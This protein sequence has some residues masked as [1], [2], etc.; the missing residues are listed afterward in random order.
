LIQGLVVG[1]GS[2]DRIADL[3]LPMA[4]VYG[5]ALAGLGLAGINLAGA[6]L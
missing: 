4:W 3:S 6:L 5:L 2:E 1:P